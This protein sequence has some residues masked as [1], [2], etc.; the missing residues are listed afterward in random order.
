[1]AQARVCAPNAA[2]LGSAN[3]LTASDIGAFIVMSGEYYSVVY[4]T[5]TT[6][7]V[8]N[9]STSCTKTW[10]HFAQQSWW[11]GDIAGTYQPTGYWYAPSGCYHYANMTAN[12]FHVSWCVCLGWGTSSGTYDSNW[13]AAHGYGFW[14]AAWV[15]GW[16]QVVGVPPLTLGFYCR[17]ELNANGFSYRYPGCILG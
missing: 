1:V 7:A 8:A 5:A 10:M 9:L 17:G 11:F 4:Q 15:N 3:D 12:N 2:I 16:F 14:A 6:S 13:A